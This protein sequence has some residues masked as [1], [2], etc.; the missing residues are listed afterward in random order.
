MSGL[1]FTRCVEPEDFEPY[2]LKWLAVIIPIVG[3]AVTFLAIIA[4]ATAA[5]WGVFV[6]WGVIALLVEFLHYTLDWMLNRKLICLHQQAWGCGDFGNQVC[7]IGEVGDIEL[8]GEDKNPLEDVDNDYC[9]NLVLAPIDQFRHH[10]FAQNQQQIAENVKLARDPDRGAIQA[11]LITEQPGMPEYKDNTRTFIWFGPHTY[12]EGSSMHYPVYTAWTTY[13]GHDDADAQNE[14]WT[15]LLQQDWKG[16]FAAAKPWKYEV[17]VLHSEFEGSRINDVLQAINAF[18]FGGE[19]CKKNWLFKQI[20]RLLRAFFSP[21]ALTQALIAWA[22]ATAGSQQPALADPQA[23]EAVPGDMVILRGRWV[24]DGYHGYN[25]MHAV[26]VLQK[27][28]NVP[29]VDLEADPDTRKKQ[30]GEFTRFPDD[31]C[32]LLCEAPLEPPL[33]D[34]TVGQQTVLDGQRRPENQWRLHPALD[35]CVAVQ[36]QVPEP[37]E[38]PR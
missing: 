25:E 9:I 8:V 18:S 36:P 32:R 35:S 2:D 6:G 12:V 30:I 4:G 13:L 14:A 31:W 5:A 29:P 1:Q 33:H 24:N 28:Y 19:W 20:C 15:E 17:P 27:V 34:V 38:I 11:D 10:E 23:G 3:G 22:N 21:L 7:A 37:P 26:R 16:D